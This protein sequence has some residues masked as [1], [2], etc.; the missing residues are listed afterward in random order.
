MPAAATAVAFISERK[1]RPRMV[2]A[3]PT[4]KKTKNKNQ[5]RTQNIE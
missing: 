4:H 5:N 1:A 2:I 3:E